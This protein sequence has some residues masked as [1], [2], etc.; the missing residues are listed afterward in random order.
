MPRLPGA[1]NLAVVR[2]P[3]LLIAILAAALPA[4]DPSPEARPAAAGETGETRPAWRGRVLATPFPRPAFTLADTRGQPF[5]FATE[6]DGEV[7][8]LFFGFTHCP[9]VCP[10]HMANI[11]A[12]LDDLGWAARDRIRVV[13][14]STDPDRD[15][16]ERIRAWL[17]RFDPRFVG[18]RGTL[19]EVNGIQRQLGLPP[20]VIDGRGEN[21]TVG[22]AAQVLAFSAD[23]PARVVYPFGTR[24]V[25]WAADLPRLLAG[26]APVPAPTGG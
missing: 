9:D 2:R 3:I 18:L 25:D 19:D 14:V 26:E 7:A 22:H 20:S 16:P 4:C 12:V 13:F 15:T 8:L 21:Y 1:P 11:A 17:D 23:G 5:D 10:V 24:Q 6:T